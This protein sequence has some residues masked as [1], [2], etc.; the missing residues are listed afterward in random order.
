MT[1]LWAL[2][3]AAIAGGVRA[4]DFSAREAVAA[5]LARMDAANPAINAVVER[6]DA[7][8]LA[9]AEAVDAAR[10]AGRDPGPLAGVPVTVK[11]IV[12]VAGC[13]TTNG[14]TILKDNIAGQDAPAVANLRRAG[15]VVVGITAT[16]A[17]SLRWFTRSR[18][19]GA[20]LNPRAPG[21]TPGGSSGGAAAAL[22][23][24]IGAL[25][26]GTDIG[27]SVRYPAFACGVHGLRPSPGRVPAHNASLP[28]RHLGAQLMAVTG[29]LAREVG[30]LR[31]AL[32]AMSAPDP[33]DPWQ[34]PVPLEGPEAP[35]RAALCVAPEGMA[36]DG[37]VALGLRAAAEALA[38]AG[39]RVV[40]TACPPLREP[41]RLQALL[42]L[43]EL[44]HAGA[45]A[46]RREADPDADFVFA[47]LSALL[48]TPDLGAYLDALQ[49]RN[50]LCRDWR[51]F[52]RDHPVL[53]C[54]VSAEPPFADHRDVQSPE[55]FLAVAEAQ[56][57]Q[58]AMP[59][60]GLPALALTTGALGG[61]LG[62]V[63]IVADRHRED[64]ALA[65]AEAIAAR[66][67]AVLPC[68]PAGAAA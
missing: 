46:A 54:P 61:G 1:A 11:A 49:A 65:A 39:W 5:A 23:A 62:G 14:L 35:R 15:A 64:V 17:F 18:L 7:A 56:V 33:R 57:T 6:R 4:G 52:L 50:R 13:A 12:D 16:P 47:Q 51:L 21:L 40:E 25:A 30:D 2:S 26:V 8:A 67:P 28:E 45:E 19:Y 42:W 53:L 20:T 59:F 38:D 63:Q 31:L 22:A 41:A 37:A 43:A 48:P 55:D 36:V 58:T 9:E 34:A 10:A 3:A 44:R 68:D 24:G 60:L 32:A 66:M 29:P 27:G